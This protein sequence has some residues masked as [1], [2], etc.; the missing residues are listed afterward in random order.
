M[1]FNNNKKKLLFK[2]HYEI[3]KGLTNL[4]VVFSDVIVNTG[5][6]YITKYVNLLYLGVDGPFY[7]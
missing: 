6:I 5:Q 3:F 1:F 7:V 2:K 4:C